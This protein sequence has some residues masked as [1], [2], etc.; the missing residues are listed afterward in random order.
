MFNPF[1]GGGNCG[2]TYTKAEIDAMMANKA[3]FDSLTGLIPTSEIPPEVFERMKVVENDTARF[4][5]TTSDV[6]NGDVVYVNSD[7]I[8]YYVYDDTKLNQEAGYKAFASGVAA[9]AIADKNGNDI[10]ETYQPKI[11]SQHK[12]SADNVDD[13]QSTNKFNVQANWAES[14]SASPAY[15]NNK[16]TL[17]TA[18]ALDVATTGDAALT[19]VVKGDDSRL[20]DSRNPLAHNQASDT[21]NAM[22]S[23]AKAQTD[24]S[25]TTSDTLNEA[26]GKL[27]YKVDVNKTNI[28]SEQAKTTG[29]TEGGSNYIT[30]GGIRVYVSATAPTGNIPDGSVGVG[31]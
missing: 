1:S 6:Q 13:S 23:Y 4:A 19:E 12:I 14:N 5:L 26:V 17:G 3:D 8:M 2:H 25:I 21:I 28:L 15:I 9:K 24:S 18:S 22:T 27:E 31:W 16:P 20:T 11:D 30:V 7:Q 10:T 29:M